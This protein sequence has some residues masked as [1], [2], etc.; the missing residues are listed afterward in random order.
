MRR[1]VENA[2]CQAAS[3]STR[4]SCFAQ[5][6]AIYSRRAVTALA[7]VHKI[8]LR[9]TVHPSAVAQV[10]FSPGICLYVLALP[11]LSNQLEFRDVQSRFN[12]LSRP[13]TSP[14]SGCFEMY[15]SSCEIPP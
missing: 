13:R 3:I 5:A 2:L 10:P 7:L 1:K 11:I 15:H 12:G 6:P 4:P 8:D 14:L 9:G